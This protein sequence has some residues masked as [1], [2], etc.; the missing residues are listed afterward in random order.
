MVGEKLLT[1][2][3][4]AEKMGIP[5]KSLQGMRHREEGP[6]YIKIGRLV[7]YSLSQV[8]K[9]LASQTHEPGKGARRQR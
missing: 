2:V 1:E 3:E 9:Y 6:P 7:R 4:L 5:V 8:E